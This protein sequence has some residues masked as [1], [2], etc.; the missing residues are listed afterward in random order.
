MLY[1]HNFEI[2][3]WPGGNPETGYMDTDSSP[4]KSAVLATE[5]DPEFK[6]LWALNFG[7]LPANQLFNLSQDPDCA[8]NLADRQDFTALQT[9][10]FSELK[11]QGD[12]RMY[13]NGN[14]FDKYPFSDPSKRHY[15]AR[16]MS[17]EAVKFRE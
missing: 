1:L 15:F 4:T 14:V 13:G 17:G 10:L 16:L 2:D 11:K 3:R 7:K 5:K 12:P 6:H 9:Q 8:R